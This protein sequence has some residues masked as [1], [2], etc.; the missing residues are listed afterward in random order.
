MDIDGEKN[1]ADS[2]NKLFYELEL[3]VDFGM[4]ISFV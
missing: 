3:D 1:Q 4:M 2:W